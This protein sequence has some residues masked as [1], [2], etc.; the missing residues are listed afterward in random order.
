MN[1]TMMALVVKGCD[2]AMVTDDA[3]C[4]MEKIGEAD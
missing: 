2:D 1:M 4:G 3:A